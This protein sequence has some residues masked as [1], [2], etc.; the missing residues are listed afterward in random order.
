MVKMSLIELAK[1]PDLDSLFQYSNINGKLG[2]LTAQSGYKRI[3]FNENKC[4]V[5]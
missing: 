2:R 1:A 3:S 4:E 5:K